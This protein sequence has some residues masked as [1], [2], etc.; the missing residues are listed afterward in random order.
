M[1]RTEHIDNQALKNEQEQI[2]STLRKTTQFL[3]PAIHFPTPP[4]EYDIY[5]TFNI[6]TGKIKLG[7]S[8]LART[9]ASHSQV[10]IDGYIGII[11]DDF[12]QRLDRELRVLGVTANWIDVA[13]AMLEENLIESRVAPYLGGDDPLFGRLYPGELADFFNPDKIHSLQPNPSYKLNIIYGCGAALAGW[14][15]LLV[16]VD[17][18]KVEIQYRSRAGCV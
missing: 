18:P 12:R 3:M 10:I 15:G 13:E 6:G 8:A 4:G 17:I 7:F 2:Y 5:P 9:I 16:Y 14:K 11:W 1:R